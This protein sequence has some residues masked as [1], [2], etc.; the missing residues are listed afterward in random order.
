MTTTELNRRLATLTETQI[1]DITA[2]IKQG[3]GAQGIVNE[4]NATLKQVNAVFAALDL[5]SLAMGRK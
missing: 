2:M 1:A 5:R 3:Y 4:Y